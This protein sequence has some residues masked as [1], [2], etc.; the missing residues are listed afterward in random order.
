LLGC[1]DD[2]GGSDAKKVAGSSG[3]AVADAQAPLAPA[4]LLTGHTDGVHAVAFS[5]DGKRVVT[6]SHDRT[7]RLWDAATAAE[8]WRLEGHG[9]AVLGGAFSADGRR[10]ATCGD[11]SLVMVWDADSGELIAILE[12]HQFIVF[13]VAFAPDGSVLSAGQDGS[14]RRWD[15][16]GEK[17]IWAVNGDSLFPMCL[18]VSPDGR[19]FATGGRSAFVTVWDLAT[20]RPLWREKAP[21]DDEDEGELF[22]RQQQDAAAGARPSAASTPARPDPGAINTVVFSPDGSRLFSQRNQGAVHEWDAA[23]GRLVRHLEP[24]SPA[25]AVDVSPDGKWLFIAAQDGPHVWES[26]GSPMPR[27]TALTLDGY[28]NT[29]DVA[30]SPDGRTAAMGYGGGWVD[31][32]AW[33]AAGPTPVPLWDLSRFDPGPAAAPAPAPPT[34]K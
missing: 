32:M 1:G 21:R 19:T 17:Q 28:T 7:A 5:P 3:A 10:V 33:R 16:E 27:V 25:M 23:T 29:H 2:T 24:F 34:G 26:Q 9:G 14:V 6:A 4:R 22:A 15:V 11:D 12:G 18:D 31:R 13:A 20:G 8:L 30:F